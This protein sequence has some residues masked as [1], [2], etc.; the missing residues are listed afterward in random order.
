MTYKSN[1]Y[2]TSGIVL[3]HSE[4][5]HS[6]VCTRRGERAVPS[7]CPWGAHTSSP[8]GFQTILPPIRSLLLPPANLSAHLLVALTLVLAVI[9]PSPPATAQGRVEGRKPNSQ[10][11]HPQEGGTP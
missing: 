11:L 8:L 4:N 9:L 5:R 6:K 2:I 1:I 3:H 10:Q 7:L